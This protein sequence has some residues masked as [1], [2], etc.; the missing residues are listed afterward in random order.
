M[1]RLFFYS[2]ILYNFRNA[3][4]LR[5]CISVACLEL[6]AMDCVIEIWIQT[7][8]IFEWLLLYWKRDTRL[9]EARVRHEGKKKKAIIF[10][11]TRNT[12]N[13]FNGTLLFI[14]TYRTTVNN[15]RYPASFPFLFA[16]ILRILCF[17]PRDHL[18]ELQLHEALTKAD[19]SR[20]TKHSVT[21][22]QLSQLF[23]QRG[24]TETIGK[25]LVETAAQN[26]RKKM[27]VAPRPAATV[28]LAPKESISVF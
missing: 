13:C 8:E 16:S 9:L 2:V 25:S 27:E 21:A 10:F 26:G 22:S 3:K 4:I 7:H 18:L 14:N 17:R 1:K 23:Q 19:S 24:L 5:L 12:A 28:A 6:N 15:A 20:A 11:W